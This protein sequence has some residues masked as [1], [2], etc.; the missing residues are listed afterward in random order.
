MRSS[1]SSHRNNSAMPPGYNTTL[2]S[3][4]VRLRVLGLASQVPNTPTACL[5]RGNCITT[6]ATAVGVEVG[7]Q[8]SGSARENI[9]GANGEQNRG[10]QCEIFE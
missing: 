3:L 7:L 4:R 5:I 9:L 10:S 8:Q 2:R 1:L 6:L